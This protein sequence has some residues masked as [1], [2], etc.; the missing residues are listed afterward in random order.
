MSG[1]NIKKFLNSF[2]RSYNRQT[3]TAGTAS[4][5]NVQTNSTRVEMDTS[6]PNL[7]S[8]NALNHIGQNVKT[9]VHNFKLNVLENADRSAY[10]KEVLNLPKNMNEFIYMVQQNLTK[11]Q[12]SKELAAQN[13][14][15]QQANAAQTQSKTLSSIESQILSQQAY[16]NNAGTKT[17]S[18]QNLTQ[19][20]PNITPQQNSN[21]LTQNTQPQPENLSQQTQNIQL[22]QQIYLNNA[23]TKSLSVQN[24]TQ[25]TQSGQIQQNVQ[26]SQSQQLQNQTATGGA[27]QNNSG[28]QTPN[29]SILSGQVINNNRLN[30]KNTQEAKLLADI[31]STN[32]EVLPEETV[33]I[34]LAKELQNTLKKLSI[35]PGCMIS[36]GDISKLLQKNGKTAIT[37]II[38]TMTEASKSGIED[39][40]QMKEMAKFINASISV[41]AENNPQKTLKLF[42]LLYLPWLPLEDGVN[43]DIEIEQKQ[44]NSGSGESDS[45]LVITVTT[46]N[47][48]TVRAVLILET[49]NSVQVSI[50][51]SENF[52]KK[53]LK[54][55][56][57]KEQTYYSM[58]SVISFKTD[59]NIKQ[60]DGAK[61]AASVNLSQTTEMNPFLLLM[62]HALIKHI[63]AIDNN[64]TL[65]IT[66]HEDK[67]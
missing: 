36:L 35:N 57:E 37:K 11:S 30:I 67:F 27:A 41:A 50:E 19:Q 61:Q 59:E 66:S 17:H 16:M 51:S 2:T 56:I 44:E 39:L 54:L 52:P 10:L 15:Q 13:P 42:L 28:I 25:Q 43:F 18:I 31:Y 6:S 34:I 62:A 60:T 47:Y 12:L 55:R 38:M 23:G 22:Q 7:P 21:N 14:A 3:S 29:Q 1:I 9:L 8:K 48:G 32:A 26:N 65:G 20:K 40:S 46:I 45:I 5:S 4:A 53:E 63:I 64:K 33:E 58:D 24:L 49:S